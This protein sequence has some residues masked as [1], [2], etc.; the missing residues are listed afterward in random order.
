MYILYVAFISLRRW[1]I[2][3]IAILY[4]FVGDLLSRGTISRTIL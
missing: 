3:F 4:H 1:L 2:S